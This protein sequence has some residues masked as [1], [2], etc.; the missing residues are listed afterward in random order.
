MG[1]ALSSEPELVTHSASPRAQRGLTLASSVSDTRD[2][3]A[4]TTNL[5]SPHPCPRPLSSS[6]SLSLSSPA[7]CKPPLA[8]NPADIT[9]APWCAPQVC[10]TIAPVSR[11]SCT[12]SSTPRL[13]RSLGFLSSHLPCFLFL[14]YPLSFPLLFPFQSSPF[15]LF[16]A[17]VSPVLLSM[18]SFASNLF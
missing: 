6:L 7:I 18:N 15:A 11:V 16:T 4:N 12:L 9:L 1:R 5:C 2:G 3:R 14:K 8:S 10:A 13:L 17:L